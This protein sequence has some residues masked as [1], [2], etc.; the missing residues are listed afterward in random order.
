MPATPLPFL[1]G[2]KTRDGSS[3]S[4]DARNTNVVLEKGKD[5]ELLV[6]KRPGF[7]LFDGGTWTTAAGLGSTTLPDG[8]IISFTGIVT[9]GANNATFHYSWSPNSYSVFNPFNKSSHIALTNSNRTATSDGV[10]SFGSVGGAPLKTTGKRYAEFTITTVGANCGV[11]IADGAQ[12]LAQYIGFDTHGYGWDQAGGNILYNNAAL[13]AP[14]HYTTGDVISILLDCG[15]QMLIFWKNGVQK[16]STV[17]SI[18]M[19]T[20]WAPGM[21]GNGTATVVTLNVGQTPWAYTP[22]AG[23]GPWYL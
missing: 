15:A 7:Q 11:G 6:I 14:G 21:N 2:L 18:S 16:G 4:K 9:G 19:A 5:G 8:T 13:S 23:F 12:N 10:A 20:G 17:M 3:T 1:F 22:S